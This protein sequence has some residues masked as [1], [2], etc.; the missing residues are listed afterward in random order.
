M[1]NLGSI[2]MGT[3][4][5]KEM[6]EFYEKVFD[7]APEWNDGNWYGWQL[8]NTHF[9]LGEHSEM[10]GKAKDP[11]RIMFN[12]DTKDVKGE[13]E[14]IKKAGAEVVKE[15]YKPDEASDMWIAT[16]AD[17]DGNYF[18]LMSPWEDQK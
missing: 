12:L 18:Q 13:F 15:P 17:L 14:R 5:P 2:M 16:F 6:A 9:T 11:G 3:M 1:L 10:G 8:G 4:Q 7:K